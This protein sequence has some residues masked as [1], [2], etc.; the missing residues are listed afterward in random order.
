M[1]RMLWLRPSRPKPV[2]AVTETSPSTYQI[3]ECQAGLSANKRLEK[4]SAVS[5]DHKLSARFR[6]MKHSVTDHDVDTWPE[7]SQLDQKLKI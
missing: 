4:L 6:H 3:D 5:S 1:E 7:F 2:H